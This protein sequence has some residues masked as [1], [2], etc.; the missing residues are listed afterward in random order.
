M[1]NENKILPVAYWQ[2][3]A[4]RYF[5]AELTKSW[6]EANKA[7]KELGVTQYFLGRFQAKIW[8]CLVWGEVWPPIGLFELA[9]DLYSFELD[10]SQKYFDTLDLLVRAGLIGREVFGVFPGTEIPYS[11]IYQV[12]LQITAQKM[13]LG[14]NASSGPS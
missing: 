1:E 14:Y 3:L 4:L 5:G 12:E 10:L 13:E 7:L 2:K 11:M 9:G 6:N 8:W